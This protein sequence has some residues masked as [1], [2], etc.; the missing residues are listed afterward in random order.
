[1]RSVRLL[2]MVALVAALACEDDP[3]R[4]RMPEAPP[5]PS[6]GVQAFVQVSRTEARPGEEIWVFVRV[7][8]GTDTDAKLGSYTGRLAFNPE[9]LAFKSETKINDGLRVT[10]PNGAGE[11]ELRFAGASATGFA[12]LTLFAGVFEVKKTG[13]T[14]VL[15]LTMEEL[16]AA[17][18]LSDLTP[19]L[20][21]PPQ[22]FLRPSG[23]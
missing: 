21:L 13:Y 8:L 18:T 3:L 4:S 9:V 10:N 17:L 14:S 11:G 12:D 6:R 16:S 7:Q 15:K 1:M 20:D 23:N 19:T 5:P 2:T 22:I